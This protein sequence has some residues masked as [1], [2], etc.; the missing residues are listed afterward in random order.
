MLVGITSQVLRYSA[1][2]VTNTLVIAGAQA[3]IGLPAFPA[4]QWFG[5][6]PAPLPHQQHHMYGGAYMA[7]QPMFPQ[8][9][10]QQSAFGQF[11]QPPA[12]QAFWPQCVDPTGQVMGQPVQWG[13]PVRFGV[14]PHTD[15]KPFVPLQVSVSFT[16]SPL[17]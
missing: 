15:T 12:G 6:V 7:P 13:Q 4:P 14:A 2:K 1:L 8:Q 17:L 10:F 5:A 9:M 11:A 16:Q 3:S